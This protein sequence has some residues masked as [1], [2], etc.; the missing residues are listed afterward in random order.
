MD[1]FT[2]SIY[3]DGTKNYVDK[4]IPKLND[5]VNIGLSMLDDVNA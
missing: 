1:L 4:P 5:N 2:K 3:S